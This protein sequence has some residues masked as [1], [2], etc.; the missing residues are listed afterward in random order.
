[1]PEDN[2]KYPCGCL[3]CLKKSQPTVSRA[4]WFNHKAA[5]DSQIALGHILPPDPSLPTPI[6]RVRNVP[7]GAVEEHI[8]KRFRRSSIVDA[9]E[10]A[11]DI[12]LP[13]VD[14]MSPVCAFFD[15]L[16]VHI[17]YHTTQKISSGSPQVQVEETNPECTASSLVPSPP[18]QLHIT[19]LPDPMALDTEFSEAAGPGFQPYPDVLSDL[20][21]VRHWDVCRTEPILMT[22]F[23]SLILPRDSILHHSPQM[24]RFSR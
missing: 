17:P 7:V 2:L 18:L 23:Y 8:H 12:L 6:K 13:E 1:M 3:T 9:P 5:R 14:H 16:W 21:D 10:S 22:V 20:I 11:T 24:R 19:D 15:R 4:T